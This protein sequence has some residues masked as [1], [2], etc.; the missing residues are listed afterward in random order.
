VLGEANAAAQGS[1]INIS[2][3]CHSAASKLQAGVAVWCGAYMA[4]VLLSTASE[5]V[6]MLQMLMQAGGE[7]CGHLFSVLA[8]HTVMLE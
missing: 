2:C 1:T 5:H 3:C 7:L 8:H 4:V 6:V